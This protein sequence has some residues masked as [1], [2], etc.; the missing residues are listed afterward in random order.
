MK[1]CQYC[2]VFLVVPSKYRYTNVE[3]KTITDKR[4]CSKQNKYV[5]DVEDACDKFERHDKFW[6]KRCGQWQKNLAC[7]NRQRKNTE[8]CVNCFQG[9][10]ILSIMR[11][12][13]KTNG[14]N[15]KPTLVRQPTL[16][17]RPTL[18][19]NH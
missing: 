19:R 16:I 9:K 2:G 14:N 10:T 8:G 4:W 5:Q 3:G 18:N 13:P 7:I 15:G 6:C 1:E 17:R 12:V 11:G